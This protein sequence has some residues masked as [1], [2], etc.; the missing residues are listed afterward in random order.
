[1]GLILRVQFLATVTQHAYQARGIEVDAI[2]SRVIMLGNLS[3]SSG[4][5]D[6]NVKRR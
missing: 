1:M 2:V 6:L 4:R 3:D 5:I